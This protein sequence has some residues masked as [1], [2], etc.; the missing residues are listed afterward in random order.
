MFELRAALFQGDQLL[1]DIADD[2]RTPDGGLT[3]ISQTQNANDPAVEKVQLAL[4]DWR[5]DCLPNFGADG[6]FGEESA[7]AVHRFKAEELG[8]AEGEIINDVGPLTVQRLDAIRAA[9]EA[10]VANSVVTVANQYGEA[11]AGVLVI[12]NDGA[13]ET[14]ATT[15]E[16]GRAALAV[17][18]EA[19]ISL[20]EASL[21]AALGDLLQRPGE[22]PQA[23]GQT[24]V[25]PGGAVPA[26]LAVG[27]QLDLIVAARVDLAVE[28]LA[29]LEGSPRVEGPGLTIGFD[30]SSAFVAL[31]AVGGQSASVQID[32][33]P[34]EA[35]PVELP[36]LGPWVLP[37][38]YVV[39]E[40]DTEEAL[41]GRFLGDPGAFARL[42]DH[43][44]TAGE[45]LTLPA[46]SV[47]GWVAAAAAPLPD[48]PLPRTWFSV[49]PDAILAALYSDGDPAPFDELTDALAAPPAAGED[50]LAVAAARAEAIAAFL[51]LGPDGGA[52]SVQ[53]PGG[54]SEEVVI[55]GIQG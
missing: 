14:A 31:Q 10:P 5:P 54:E 20:D 7:I 35:T 1:Q 33:P 13:A 8:V 18:A 53:P 47:P 37:D 27:G 46:D 55:D 36:P 40:G 44:P 45:T 39:Q 32:P 48:P 38:G 11:L 3:R 21:L 51:A 26:T 50:P 29:P 41:A 6:G 25:V 43:P 28:M 23:A 24:V 34:S 9:A 16:S 4:L 52:A 2:V 30:E 22:G 17:G 42:S 49:V 19:A 12:A 15:D